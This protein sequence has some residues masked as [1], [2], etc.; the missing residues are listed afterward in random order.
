MGQ[1]IRNCVAVLVAAGLTAAPAACGG[2]SQP[3]ASPTSP[4][5]TPTASATPTSASA[6]NQ[7]TAEIER[8]F[9]RFFSGATPA[10]TKVGLV[11]NGQRFA[12]VIQAQAP[13][14]LAKST[15]AT[16]GKVAVTS[17]TTATVTYTIL[18]GGKP[19]LEN[20]AG[21]AVLVSGG[22]KVAAS[23]FCQLLTLEGQKVP[24]CQ[25]EG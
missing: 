11:Q 17:P 4:S 10:A 16:V 20:Q 6:G 7:A 12:A 2:S 9:V 25:G 18:L 5:S 22:W 21:Q 15:T 1:R 23:T 14:E 8:T 13:T 19:A 24:G 3:S